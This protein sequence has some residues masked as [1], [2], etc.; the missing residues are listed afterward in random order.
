MKKRKLSSPTKAKVLNLA[1]EI[2]SMH[3]SVAGNRTCQ[4]W[5][6]P[7]DMHPHLILTNDEADD[8]SFNY[9]LF[10]SSGEDYEKGFSF[11]HDEMVISSAL[12]E[13]ISDLAK[14]YSE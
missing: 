9:E 6:G 5:S 2:L 3:S 14:E 1:A 8:L 4:D 11:F 13:A 7:K 10:N 12:S